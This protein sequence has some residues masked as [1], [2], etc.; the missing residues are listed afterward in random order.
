MPGAAARHERATLRRGYGPGPRQA[1]RCGGCRCACGSGRIGCRRGGWNGALSDSLRGQ[2]AVV[3]GGAAGIGL[4]C[5]ERLVAD[6]AS[7]MLVDRDAEGARSAAQHIG[8][9]VVAHAADAT[10]EVGVAAVFGAALERFNRLDVLVNGAGGF[11]RAPL[12]EDLPRDEWDEVLAWNLTS[13]YLCC[14]AA[15]PAMKSAGY[16]RIVN[17]SSMAGRTAAAGIS[18]A[19]NAAKAGVIGLTRGLA[20]ELAP[21]GVTVNAV[22]PGVVLSPRVE[23]LHAHRMDEILAATPIGRPAQA[24]EVADVVLFLASPGASYVTGATIDVTGGRFIG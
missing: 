5:V 24:T 16:G 4:A 10:D 18:H 1:G 2:V 23:K 19:Y 21:L 12:I 3:T 22:A 8:D 11:T 20:L 13:T 14:R 17:I 6:G 15:V 7:V 9:G